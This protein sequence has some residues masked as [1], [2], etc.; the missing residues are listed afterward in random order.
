MAF[1]FE[2]ND[3]QTDG[4]NGV[5]VPFFREASTQEHGVRGHET[6]KTESQ[7]KADIR[8]AVEKLGGVVSAIRR[9]TFNAFDPPREGYVIEFTIHGNPGEL[10]VAALPFD[11][12]RK[13]PSENQRKKA[14]KQALYTVRECLENQHNLRMLA[15]GS[16]PLLPYML[17]PDGTATLGEILETGRMPLGSG[18]EDHA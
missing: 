1:G 4:P 6:K 13:D 2:P 11:P 3:E 18:D 12:D 8:R 5:D 9:G 17:A 15:P 16:Q 10:T 14:R 7:L